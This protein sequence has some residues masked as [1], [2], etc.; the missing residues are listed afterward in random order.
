MFHIENNY[1]M[2]VACQVM[3]YGQIINKNR[4]QNIKYGITKI[5]NR[6]QH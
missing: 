6:G 1:H 5:C 3:L 2:F 4:K